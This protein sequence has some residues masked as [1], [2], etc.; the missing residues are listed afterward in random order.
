M[1][2]KFT[3]AV[4]GIRCVE[5]EKLKLKGRQWRGVSNRGRGMRERE[6]EREQVS[7]RELMEFTCMVRGMRK[8]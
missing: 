5:I 6:T 1:W 2:I 7:M 4:K 8:G 3:W